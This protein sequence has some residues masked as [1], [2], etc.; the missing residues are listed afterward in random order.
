MPAR[1]LAG[2][3]NPALGC[4]SG[5]GFSRC[6]KIV[7]PCVCV[8]RNAL[9][10]FFGPLRRIHD[11][12]A[13]RQRSVGFHFRCRVRSSPTS[14][15]R[16]SPGVETQWPAGKWPDC[17]RRFCPRIM[18]EGQII[19]HFTQR[20]D[21]FRQMLAALS[22]ACEGKGRLHPRPKPVLKRL[23]VFAEI[24]LLAMM[25]NERRLEIECIRWPPPRP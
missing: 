4:R 11:D 22:M 21:G 5:I 3:T 10:Q 12:R 23:H 16:E 1:W 25:S 18:Y 8:G 15:C 7:V 2:V 17:A 20:R 13:T 24:A 6:G 9:A 14:P 19:H